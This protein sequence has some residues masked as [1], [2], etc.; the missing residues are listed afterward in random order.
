MFMFGK[1][2]RAVAAGFPRP[3]TV[4]FVQMLHVCVQVGFVLRLT[5]PK[6]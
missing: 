6:P 2:V 3:R 4:L 1:H 5:R